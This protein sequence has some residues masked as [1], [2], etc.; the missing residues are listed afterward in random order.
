MIVQLVVLRP[1]F[2]KRPV[3]AEILAMEN[4]N[5]TIRCDPEAAPR[6]RV[7]WRKDGN[8]IGSGG[9]RQILPSGSLQIMPV[10]RDDAGIYT[11]IAT[12]IRGTEDSTGRLTVLRGPILVEQLPDRIQYAVGSQL[13]LRCRADADPSL[14]ISYIWRHN[15]LRIDDTLPRVRLDPRFGYLEIFNLTLADKGDYECEVISWVGKLF[16]GSRVEI[17]GPPG[18]PGGVEAF[19]LSAT[20]A[21]V[22]WTDGATN[23]AI[24][25]LYTIEGRTQWDSTWDLLAISKCIWLHHYFH[26]YT[27]L[28][29]D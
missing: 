16:S 6:P 19:D 11:C 14:D 10:S 21:T 23:G 22:R 25:Y 28:L 26:R 27:D 20:N 18:P 24:A 8:L 1:S 9:R 12:N 13:S 15:G 7:Q 4:G 5:V 2:K 17:R 3:D 29:H